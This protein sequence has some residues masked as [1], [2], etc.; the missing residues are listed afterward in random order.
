MNKIIIDPYFIPND[1]TI[2]LQNIEFIFDEFEISDD[3]GKDGIIVSVQEN[4]V[5]ICGR[6]LP[7]IMMCGDDFSPQY[8]KDVEKNHDEIAKGN[9][10][11]EVMD[12]GDIRIGYLRIP[13]GNKYA[14][15]EYLLEHF[16]T[17]NED[18]F[19]YW[20]LLDL[21][22]FIFGTM[23]T[24]MNESKKREIKEK[25]GV[26]K[27]YKYSRVH[28]ISTSKKK[29]FLFDDIV[30]YV[31]EHRD[32]ANFKRIMFCPCWEVR[33]HY[34]HYKNGKVVFIKSYKKGK[35]RDRVE[36]KDREYIARRG[37]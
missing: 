28:R 6:N 25:Q 7:P 33:G 10:A 13:K 22:S 32:D 14:E 27:Q 35:Q 21:F 19:Y 9:M 8:I 11:V 24:I 31:Y 17:T 4:R 37:E 20:E 3:V 23:Q 16:C 5:K 1:G 30:N 2:D 18:E 12:D 29:I 15:K 36:P 26:G 34:R